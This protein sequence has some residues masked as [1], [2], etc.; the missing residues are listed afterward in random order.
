LDQA[1][2]RGSACP[3]KLPGFLDH[4]HTE[5][6][7]SKLS[8][9]R[10]G[11]D[12]GVLNRS[13]PRR[14]TR[15]P[16]RRTPSCGVKGTQ[17]SDP[18][19]AARSYSWMRPPQYTVPSNPRAVGRRRHRFGP[20]LRRPQVK[21]SMGP[22][23][24][25]MGGVGPEHPLQVAAA[26]HQHPV[27]ALGPDRSHPP[28][29]KRVRLRGPDRRLEDVHSLGAEASSKRTG[30]LRV[31]VPDQEPNAVKPLPHRQVAGLLG[32]P[33]GVGVPGDA[34]DVHPP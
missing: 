28:L 16:R 11:L 20:W 34:E 22:G 31:P 32:H 19:Q 9:K 23:L 17:T 15:H 14:A 4:K 12:S 21:T 10:S 30:E 33:G 3:W 27:Q 1:Q 5:A 24:V 8:G 2:K 18:A 6:G 29:G 26:Q 25:V 7:R 13:R